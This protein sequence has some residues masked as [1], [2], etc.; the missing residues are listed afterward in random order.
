MEKIIIEQKNR[1]GI[2]LYEG[3]TY[4]EMVQGFN[5]ITIEQSSIPAL[6]AALEKMR[7]GE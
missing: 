2:E 6:I 4:V 1:T 3:E 5:E 7:K